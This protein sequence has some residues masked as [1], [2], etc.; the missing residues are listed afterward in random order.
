MDGG[1]AV[2]Y[3]EQTVWMPDGVGR[4]GPKTE[5][6]GEMPK[7][8]V[9]CLSP[10]IDR[11]YKLFSM[12]PGQLHRCANPVISAGGK[13]VNVARVLSMLGAEVTLTGFFAG[14]GG[15]FILDDIRSHGVETV[16]VM[17]GGETRSSINI[18]ET[19]D[20]KETEILEAGPCAGS[21]D[22]ERLMA[23][24]ADLFDG[25]GPDAWAVFSGGIP[26]GL[27]GDAYETLI[28]LAKSHGVQS[29]LDTSSEALSY[30]VRACP[31]MIKP[32][33]REFSAITGYADRIGTAVTVSDLSAIRESALPLGIPVV[34]VTLS[35]RGAA[36]V[37]ED[38]VLYA[39]PLPVIPVNTI[40]SGDSFTAGFT[41]ELL[42]GGSLRGALSLAVACASS[43]ALFERVGIIDPA[44]A[45]VLRSQVVIEEYGQAGESA[46]RLSKQER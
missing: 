38:S 26:E 18:L 20:G 19:G 13:G 4:I 11:N 42:R 34:A 39:H 30:G 15:R 32:N 16:P 37:T 23:V 2:R 7:I 17:I 45:A 12:T 21:G 27:P 8:I 41:D 25:A 44:Q 46:G 36:V 35:S 22:F 31:Y 1:P 5:S 28:R 6:A 24:S 14:S 43:N 33:L 9:V 3:N 40:G 10:A 29:I